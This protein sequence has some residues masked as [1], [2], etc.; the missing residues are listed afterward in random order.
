MVYGFT[1]SKKILLV[2]KNGA[3]LF[4]QSKVIPSHCPL[5]P[6]TAPESRV[7]AATL[8]FLNLS[9]NISLSR[10]FKIYIAEMLRQATFLE[11]EIPDAML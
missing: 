2:P 6:Q 4:L 10:S 5:P 9:Y 3:N 11:K 1:S 7:A 8:I